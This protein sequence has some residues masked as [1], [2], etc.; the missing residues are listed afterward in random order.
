MTYSI[1]FNAATK[2]VTLSIDGLI[3]LSQSLNII[4]EMVK[5]GRENNCYLFMLDG[6]AIIIQDNF[7]EIYTLFDNLERYLQKRTDK[8]AIVFKRQ[9]NIF[10]LIESV[11]INHGFTIRSFKNGDKAQRWLNIK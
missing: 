10:S 6:D 2:L 9:L 7:I 3:K 4:G 8:V 11:A 5:I 1:Q